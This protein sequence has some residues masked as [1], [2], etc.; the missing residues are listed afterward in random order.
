MQCVYVA[1]PSHCDS[2][3]FTKGKKL[4]RGPGRACQEDQL[5]LEVC[6]PPISNFLNGTSSSEKACS[7]ILNRSL[8]F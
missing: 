5:E 1:F 4:R 8:Y 6:P 2:R 7:G 3:P